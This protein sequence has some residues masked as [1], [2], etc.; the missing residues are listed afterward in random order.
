MTRS[1][2]KRESHG[3]AGRLSCLFAS[4]VMDEMDRQKISHKE[5]AKRMGLSRQVIYSHLDGEKPTTMLT[6]GKFAAAL[7]IYFH[8]GILKRG[9]GRVVRRCTSAS[10]SPRRQPPR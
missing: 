1:E 3:E 5:L 4:A 9:G 10:R 8:L 2:F 7:G 6:V